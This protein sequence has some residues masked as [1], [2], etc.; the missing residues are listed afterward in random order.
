MPQTYDVGACVYF[1]F[2]FFW[3]DLKDPVKTYCEIEDDAR[4]E[5]M[6]CGGSISHHHGVGK[7]RK[8]FMERSIDKTGIEMLKNFKKSIDPSNIFANSNLIDQ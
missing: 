8:K 4:D 3:K 7:L 6:K 1:Y 2:A 5:V